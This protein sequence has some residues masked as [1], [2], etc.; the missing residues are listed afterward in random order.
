MY[1]AKAFANKMW[2]FQSFCLPFLQILSD[3]EKVWRA[4]V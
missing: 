2:G 4:L 1:E 3:N